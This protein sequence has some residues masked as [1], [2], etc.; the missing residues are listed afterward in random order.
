M[1]HKHKWKEV[2]S[3]SVSTLNSGDAILAKGILYEC[4]KCHKQH[5]IGAT[6]VYLQKTGFTF[7]GLKVKSKPLT[8][9]LPKWSWNK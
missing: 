5:E 9:Y 1:I 2:P 3:D 7:S 8:S 4:E 6:I